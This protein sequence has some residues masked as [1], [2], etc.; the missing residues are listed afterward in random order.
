MVQDKRPN[1]PKPKRRLGCRIILIVVLGLAL[2][3]LLAAGFSFL[4]NRNLAEKCD[5]GSTLSE[6]DKAR[7]EE[8]LHLKQQL[9]DVIWPGW[10]Q[11]SIPLLIWNEEYA[12]LVGYGSPPAGWDKVPDDL[13]MDQPY[14]RQPATDTENFAVLVGQQWVG[15]MATKNETDRFVRAMFEEALPAP[16]NQIIPY[17]LLIQPSEVQ[18]TGVLHESFHVFQ[19]EESYEHLQDTELAYQNEADYWVTDKAMQ[20]AWRHEI[21]LLAQALAADSDAE[22]R[23]LTRQFL[24]HRLARRTAHDL[25]PSL[26]GYEQRLEWLEGLAKYV[27][28]ESWRLA[29]EVTGYEPLS[30]MSQDADFKAYDTY[31]QRWSQEI[32]Q[33]KRQASREGDVR[34]YYTGMAQARLLDRLA[35]DWKSQVMGNGVWL[36][37][38]LWQATR[39]GD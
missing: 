32:A 4:S 24:E 2:I 8:T 9:G 39:S 22:V 30:G 34:F 12:F 28:L 18:M 31:D 29:A 35:P 3:C 33:M 16:I 23:A 37:D 14:Y 36:E 11:A 15:S 6:L 20:E 27:E 19:T 26:V 1:A 13:F 17:R 7:L 21:D 38:L 25:Q 10:G 5:A